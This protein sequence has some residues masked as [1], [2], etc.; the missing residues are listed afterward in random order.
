MIFSLANW[1]ILAA[2]AACITATPSVAVAGDT[3]LS[4]MWLARPWEIRYLLFVEPTR[5]FRISV[6][7]AKIVNDERNPRD[8]YVS[9]K[10]YFEPVPFER[11]IATQ[12]LSLVVL[13]FDPRG[14]ARTQSRALN[15][16]VAKLTHLSDLAFASRQPGG[17]PL[18]LADWSQGIPGQIEFSPGVCEGP[19]G[20]RYGDRWN[21]DDE[22]GGFGCREWTAQLYAADRPYFDVTSYS[23]QR[24][25][26][27]QFV[28]WS[29]FEDPPKPVIGRQGDTWLCL[30]DCPPGEKPG[31]IKN[32]KAWISKHH[33][34]MPERPPKQ[35]LYP[36]ADYADSWND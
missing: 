6:R 3:E 13:E 9:A 14:R 1:R 28:G 24:A 5:G 11:S 7:A 20:R 4:G 16:L 33:F 2:S 21:T 23:G 8:L 26:I 22:A 36:D 31:V 15:G 12:P 29:R 27:G 25:F 18:Y 17:K 34:P 32:I 35:P 19:D 30:Y 10:E